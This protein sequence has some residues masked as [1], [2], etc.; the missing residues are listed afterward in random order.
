M[1]FSVYSH[2]LRQ[3]KT[4]LWFYLDQVRM[5]T[6]KGKKMTENDSETVEKGGHLPTVGGNVIFLKHCENRCGK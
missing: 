3:I 1:I 5:I 6:I 4:T 2:Q